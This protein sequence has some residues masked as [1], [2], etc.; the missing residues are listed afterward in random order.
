MKS[1]NDRI[2]EVTAKGWIACGAWSS[3]YIA[4]VVWVAW[5]DWASLGWLALLPIVMDIFTTKYIPWSWWKKYTGQVD[6][7]CLKQ[8]EEKLHA[9]LAI[10]LDIP[11]KEV[12][13]Y[14]TKALEK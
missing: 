4:F 1:F 10:A 14:I 7:R 8:A 13:D 9:E 5:G 11:V 6:E 3:I 12:R 2:K